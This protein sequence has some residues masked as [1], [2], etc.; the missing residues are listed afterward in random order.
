M[1]RIIAGAVVALFI[2]LSVSLVQATEL[3][4]LIRLLIKK[5]I[6]TE[7]EA[8]ELK[9]EIRQKEADSSPQPPAKPSPSVSE[10]EESESPVTLS[11]SIYGEYRWMNHRDIIDP[12]TDSTSDLYLRKMELGIEAA[13]T[14]WASASAVLTSEW[15]G[16]DINQGDEKVEVDEAVLT[17]QSEGF[18]LYLSLGK[19]TQPFGLFENHMIT[20]PM[21]Q[22]A[23]EAKRAGL[24]V[25][26]TGPAGLDLSLTVY[27]GE[28]QMN[29]LFESGLF[30][31]SLQR[32]GESASDDVGSFIVSA[33]ITPVE[34]ITLFGG[35]LSEPGWGQRNET[36]NA[37]VNLVPSFLEGLRIDAEYM[38]ALGREE[39]E[40]INRE[41]KEG[42]FSVTAAY[43][44]ILR[45][46]EVTGG[47]LFAE[48]RAHLIKEP[49]EVALRYEHF[50][51]DGMSETLG[52][53][54]VRDRYSIGA[55]YSFYNDETAGVNAFVA[56]E[57]RRT[58]L[59]TDAEMKDSNDE[60]YLRL[61]V[62]F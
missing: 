7:K 47:G 36:V 1:K 46:R 6:I 25:G 11:G 14:D 24:T 17:L 55:R 51:D 43:Q 20:D 13:L 45:E 26:Y 22:D 41:Y 39:Y 58:G 54:T 32:T 61:G 3:D 15:I 53:W 37:G 12:G 62:D 52:I 38:K 21:T 27:K 40:G 23:Y 9:K 48:R 49:L 4:S 60:V 28:E 16:D 5:G 50:D 59:R 34:G 18:P 10:A 30:E 8:M 35:Y 33:L 31:E 56:G 2:L 42:V 57:Y 44:F 29:H 19:K